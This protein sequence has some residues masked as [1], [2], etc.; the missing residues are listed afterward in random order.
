MQTLLGD[1]NTEA[2][3]LV[4]ASNVFNNL[5]HQVTLANIFV[6]CPAILPVL[7]N[8]YRQPS[9]LFVGGEV[10]ISKEFTTQGDPLAMPMYALATVPLF[11]KV[12]SKETTHVWYADDAAAGG[13]LTEPTFQ[14][15]NGEVLPKQTTTRDDKAHLDIS[16]CV[17]W[18]SRFPKKPTLTYAFLILLQSHT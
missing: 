8:T 14:P 18:G 5:N 7:A 15:L 11:T 6:N 3:L 9:F 2:I 13:K 12:S 16:A 1:S 4:D 17:F 10:L